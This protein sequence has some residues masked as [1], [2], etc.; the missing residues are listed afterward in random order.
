MLT[1]PETEL[2][3]VFPRQPIP[4]VEFDFDS[5]PATLDGYA[6]LVIAALR[7]IA[8][9]D[10][11]ARI[12]IY[13]Y[14]TDSVNFQVPTQSMF[15]AVA[16]SAKRTQT[17]LDALYHAFSGVLVPQPRGR[18]LVRYSD[19]ID[20]ASGVLEFH[21][22]DGRVWEPYESGVLFSREDDDDNDDEGGA[23]ARQGSGSE[24]KP[25]S[26]AAAPEGALGDLYLLAVG[27]DSD[28]EA[29]QR[30]WYARDARFVREALV[31]AET[32]YRHTHSRL[33]LGAD[34]TRAAVLADLEWLATHLREEDVAVL[35]FSVHADR[36]EDGDAL[37]L[38]LAE[39]PET[40]AQSDLSGDELNAALARLRGRVIVLLDTCHAGALAELA[41]FQTHRATLIA[42]CAAD[43]ESGGQWLRR[44]HPHGYF[45]IALR[46]A[47]AGQVASPNGD[48]QVRQVIDSLPARTAALNPN[49][50]V[51]VFNPET[52]AS[53]PLARCTSGDVLGP[54][55]AEP[56]NAF[57]VMDVPDP[58]GEDVQAFAAEARLKCDGRDANAKPWSD[59]VVDLPDTCLEGA[60]G[61][62]WRRTHERTWN[63]GRADV[64]VQGERVYIY[65]VPTWDPEEDEQAPDG[66]LIDARRV[67]E[68]RLVGRYLNLDNLEDSTPWV[69]HI[70][71]GGRIDG[72]WTEGR[73][74]FQRQLSES[75]G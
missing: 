23:D 39:T 29:H 21:I 28:I 45:V 4:S 41:S 51:Q 59:V 74:D 16:A 47:L 31:S 75:D 25:E 34:A 73:W 7:P 26:V 70:V 46:E 52:T 43:E 18:R 55:W 37:W 48:V 63:Y 71:D 49:Q 72:I 20:P 22:A 17:V 67:G 30:D 50:Q 32:L 65:F 57:D 15:L 2:Q 36:G 8:A 11:K 42:A 19:Y 27:V 33:R 61:G 62:R 12:S 24:S 60:W 6:D 66:Y 58:D 13:G 53:V 10:P 56:L 14:F 68:D 40:Q 35:F 9:A 3:V 54:L 64:S 69:G 38:Y 44:D 5:L 1:R